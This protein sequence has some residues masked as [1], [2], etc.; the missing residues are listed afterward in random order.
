MRTKK[1]NDEDNRFGELAFEN[2]FD[3]SDSPQ[4]LW[5]LTSI[6]EWNGREVR[7]TN[8]FATEEAAHKHAAWIADGRGR[9]IALTKYVHAIE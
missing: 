8:W 5:R 7:H 3:K 1:V 6:R 2:G 9:V 4:I